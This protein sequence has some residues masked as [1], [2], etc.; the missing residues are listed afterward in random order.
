MSPPK[1]N[2]NRLFGSRLNLTL[3]I[4]RPGVTKAESGR[5]LDRRVVVNNLPK[6]SGSIDQSETDARWRE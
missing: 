3:L 6:W 5:R 4:M 2:A 1:I